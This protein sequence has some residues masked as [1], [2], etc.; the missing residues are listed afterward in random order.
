MLYFNI[1]YMLYKHIIS[2]QQSKYYKNSEIQNLFSIWE[3]NR[4]HLM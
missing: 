4:E 2:S 3:I 1:R